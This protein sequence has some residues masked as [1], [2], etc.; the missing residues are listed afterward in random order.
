[1]FR[2]IRDHKASREFHLAIK[3]QILGEEGTLGM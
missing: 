3:E 1:M 2:K